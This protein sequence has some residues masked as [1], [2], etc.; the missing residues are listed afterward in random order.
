MKRSPL[1]FLFNLYGWLIVAMS[2][3]T[4]FVV[5]AWWVVLF[6]VIGYL[7]VLL[8]ELMW[9]GSL[10]RTGRVRLARA[11]QENREPRDEKARLVGTIGELESKIQEGAALPA[12]DRGQAA[13]EDEGEHAG[14]APGEDPDRTGPPAA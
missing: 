3:V 9:G 5:R 14:P 4:A 11:E 8:V 1:W 12:P 6:G 10:G 13:S 2:V 7:V